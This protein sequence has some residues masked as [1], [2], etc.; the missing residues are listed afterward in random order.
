VTRTGAI[1]RTIETNRFVTGVTWI[2]AELWRGT[3]EDDESD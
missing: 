3:W 1:L 2:D